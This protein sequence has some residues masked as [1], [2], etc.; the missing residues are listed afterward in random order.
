LHVIEHPLGFR[1][2]TRVLML[3]GRHKD[4]ISDERAIVRVTHSLEH[5]GK[6]LDELCGMARNGERVYGSAGERCMDKA[7]REFKRRQLDADYDDDPQRF[8]RGINERWVAALMAPTSQA[9][10]LWLF[11]CDSH[12][13][14]QETAAELDQHYD[15]PL[16]PYRYPSKSGEHIVVAPFD[17][18][19]LSDAARARIHD[20]PILLWAY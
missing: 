8:Y 2:G 17:R 20:N 14:A 1:T 16:E 19:R 9:D 10:K 15:R 4:G 6:V 5:F 18:S 13:E 3:K 11:D 7:I 12:A